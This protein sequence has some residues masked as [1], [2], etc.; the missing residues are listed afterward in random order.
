MQEF[1]GFGVYGHKGLLRVHS[2]GQGIKEI[3]HPCIA[4]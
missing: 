4:K 2:F 3:S 1:P